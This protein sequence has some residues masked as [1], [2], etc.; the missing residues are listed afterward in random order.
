VWIAG[1]GGVSQGN[2]W[3]YGSPRQFGIRFNRKF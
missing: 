3:Y 2:V 1:D